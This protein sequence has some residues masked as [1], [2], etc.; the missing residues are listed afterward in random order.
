MNSFYCNGIL[1]QVLFVD[2]YSPV[3]ID[4][5]GQLRVAT[6]D[7]LTCSVHLS[8]DLTGDVLQT[9]LRHELGHVTMLSYNLLDEIHRMVKPRYWVD[10]EEWICNFMA[11]Y[12][13]EVFR[14]SNDILNGGG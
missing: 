7:P 4:R 10:I 13:S 5:T 9:V 6:T 3:L 11:D 2:P 1:W 8:R 14:I 12:G